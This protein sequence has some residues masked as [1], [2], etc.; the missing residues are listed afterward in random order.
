MFFSLLY[1]FPVPGQIQ[2]SAGIIGETC[3]GNT[4]EHAHSNPPVG[5]R[6][7][8]R[9]SFPE[10]ASLAVSCHGFA[11]HRWWAARRLEEVFHSRCSK[12]KLWNQTPLQGAWQR[13]ARP[14][15]AGA[16]IR[17]CVLIQWVEEVI[18]M[19]YCCPLEDCDP[20]FH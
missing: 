18:L 9:R 15:P 13:R 19:C 5:I 20:L 8:N 7:L 12:T 14:L 10:R 1:F 6:S 17:P 3:F 11:E 4:A 2:A 16:L